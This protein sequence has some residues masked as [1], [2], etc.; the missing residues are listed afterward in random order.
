MDH[1]LVGCVSLL[2]GHKHQTRLGIGDRCFAQR[3][4]EG[5]E[6]LIRDE[7]KFRS[8]ALAFVDVEQSASDEFVDNSSCFREPSFGPASRAVSFD[9][10]VEFRSV[11]EIL[12]GEVK[13]P[14]RK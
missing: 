9:V 10:L 7:A 13:R 8:S 5:L 6:R 1:A 11:G 12:R 3:G 4:A 2:R 14:I